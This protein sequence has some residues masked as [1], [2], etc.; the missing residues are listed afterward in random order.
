MTRCPRCGAEGTGVFCT[1]CGSPLPA[2]AA[3]DDTIIDSVPPTGSQDAPRGAAGAAVPPATPAWTSP[4]ADQ[5]GSPGS[6]NASVGTPPPAAD[7]W[8]SASAYNPSV[9]T[10]RSSYGYSTGTPVASTPQAAAGTTPQRR[11]RSFAKAIGVGVL[12]GLVLLL[13]GALVIWPMVRPSA[14][15]GPVTTPTQPAAT[16]G[17]TAPTASAPSIVT[18]TPTVPVPALGA[19]SATCANVDAD[20]AAL[21]ANLSGQ[22]QFA[23]AVPSAVAGFADAAAAAVKPLYGCPVAHSLQV[24]K[25]VSH[26]TDAAATTAIRAQVDALLRTVTLTLGASKVGR[27]SFGSVTLAEARPVYVAVLG[28]PEQTTTSSCELS[29]GKWTVLAWGG[30][31]IAFDA[32]KAGQPL[33]SWWLRTTVAHPKNVELVDSLPLTATLAQLQ[34]IKPTVTASALFANDSAPYAATFRDGLS[35]IWDDSPTTKS[36]EV[37]GGPLHLCE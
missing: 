7:Q 26:P 32:N 34:A 8:G 11:P 19:W 30:F 31:S 27:Y 12:A 9:A 24:K 14:T 22:S 3:G 25:A 21:L 1:A 29:G 37:H 35:Y 23:V 10:P 15:P 18:P 20:A 28:E 16:T 36:N 5:W 13:V 2:D 4:P 17:P 33:E 6:Y